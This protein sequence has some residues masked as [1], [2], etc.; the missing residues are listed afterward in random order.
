MHLL[1]RG[2]GQLSYSNQDWT[3]TQAFTRSLHHF[4]TTSRMHISH[5]NAKIRQ[6]TH[7]RFDS[8]WN[9]VKLKVKENTM[10]KIFNV[11]NNL[12]PS[13]IVKF[14][15]NLHIELFISRKLSKESLHILKSREIKGNN[16]TIFSHFLYPFTQKT[17]ASQRRLHE[18]RVVPT[19]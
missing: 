3:I 2:R 1:F 16:R 12:R 11:A 13:R 7:C 19:L 18:N 17:S 4:H 6:D 5:I 15:T 14:H 10:A 8:I 9:I